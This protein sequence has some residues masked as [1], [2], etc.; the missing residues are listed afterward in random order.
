MTRHDDG[1]RLRHMLEH[2]QEAIA[3]A[4]G[5]TLDD[6]RTQRVVQLALVRL[7]EIVGEAANRVSGDTQTRNPGI[8]WRQIGGMRNRFIH[9]YDAIDMSVLWDTLQIDLP[10]LIVRLKD[11]MGSP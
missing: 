5:K 9:G 7:V 8:P 10:D 3:L 2:A 4:R 11:A 6:L 1:V